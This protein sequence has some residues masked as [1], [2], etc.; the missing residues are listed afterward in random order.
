MEVLLTLPAVLPFAP[1]SFRVPSV[2]S[3]GAYVVRVAMHVDSVSH[4]HTLALLTSITVTSRS[5]CLYY[6]TLV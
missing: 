4:V 3:D 5:A 2:Y 1:L 6:F